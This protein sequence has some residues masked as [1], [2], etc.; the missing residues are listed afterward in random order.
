MGKLKSIYNLFSSKQ[1]KQ[2]LFLFLLVLAMSLLDTFGIASVMP[3][4]TL[5]T[6]EGAV[7]GNHF[8]KS[9]FD[10]LS[11]YVDLNHS[12]ALLYLITIS[13]IVISIS[14]V[15]K[16][17]VFSKIIYFVEHS[18]H[19]L[20]QELM[21]KIIG[22]EYIY[23]IKN[24]TSHLSNTVLIQTNRFVGGIIRPVLFIST[25]LITSLF[26]SFF[27]FLINP[28]VAFISFTSLF[29]IYIIIY[30]IIRPKLLGYG[31]KSLDS[32]RNLHKITSDI[33]KGVKLIK[34]LAGNQSFYKDFR[35]YSSAYSTAQAKIQISNILPNFIIEG[36]IV[37][38]LLSVF[39]VFLFISKHD[40]NLLLDE[41]LSLI[42]V[43]AFAVMRI[44]PAL[45]QVLSS[46]SI[47][48]SSVA[49]IK[50]VLHDFHDSSLDEKY[51]SECDPLTFNSDITIKNL[52]YSYNEHESFE[53]SN[54]NTK[55]NFGMFYTIVGRTGCGKSTLLDLILGILQTKTDSIF[56]DGTLLNHSNKKNWHSLLSYVPQETFLLDASI[57]ENIAFGVDPKC[58]DYEKLSY[59]SDIALLKDFI[60]NDLIDGYDSKIGES[61]VCL[62]GG[63]RQRIGIARALYCDP[64]LL[65]LDEAT[66]ALDPVTEQKIF[67]NLLALEKSVTIILVTHRI[68]NALKSDSI[69]FMEGGRLLFEG[70]YDDL[71]TKEDKFR[72]FVD[73]D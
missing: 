67:S 24:N 21:F 3:I 16:V 20:T 51:V 12:D 22:K 36:V 55:I 13:I 50:Q 64:K 11:C 8:F 14:T 61:G 34:L 9:I 60:E 6:D 65:V 27:L 71:Y 18:Q 28:F 57:A 19:Q 52:S 46:A 53:L 40:P 35:K 56:I 42:A 4:L 49:S 45:S 17:Y 32:H 58:I 31:I 68:R 69:L 1:R 38:L 48:R 39:L 37:V 7:T 30:L 70:R 23:F 10:F 33:F 15:F 43:Y 25:H 54:I 2:I 5:I 66:S 29:S 62:S 47:Y 59:I 63:Q 73:L 44:R 26:I 41:H 72:T